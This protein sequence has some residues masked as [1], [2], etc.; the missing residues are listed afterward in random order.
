MES[1]H[2][3]ALRIIIDIHGLIDFL[4]SA[5]ETQKMAER[6]RMIEN[7]RIP[8]DDSLEQYSVVFKMVDD[9]QAIIQT[10]E[11]TKLDCETHSDTYR[12]SYKKLLNK[13]T[14][15]F[16]AFYADTQ[17]SKLKIS[18]ELANEVFTKI[19]SSSEKL[20][21]LD[22]LRNKYYKSKELINIYSKVMQTA[23][24]EL[25]I[26]DKP[27]VY[28]LI[29]WIEDD[30]KHAL[31]GY[32]QTDSK[33][34]KANNPPQSRF[35][36]LPMTNSMSLKE[37]LPLVLTEEKITV[38]STNLQQISKKI[39]AG[40]IVFNS[41][42]YTPVEYNIRPLINEVDAKKYIQPQEYGVN[43]QTIERFRTLDTFGNVHKWNFSIEIHGKDAEK[44]Y[45]LETLDGKVY[46]ALAPWLASTR[47][48]VA[49]FRV[50]KILDYDTKHASKALN[51]HAICISQATKNMFLGKALE[52][53]NFENQLTDVESGKM[54][55][56][57][58][59]AIIAVADRIV[60]KDYKNKISTPLDVSDI[61]HHPDIGRAFIN[62]V[63]G[64]FAGDKTRFDAGK[65][66]MSEILASFS[67]A[68]QTTG[69]RFVREVHN[70]YSREPLKADDIG[71]AQEK[72]RKVLSSAVELVVKLDDN[73]FT[74]NYYKYLIL[75]YAG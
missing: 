6:L 35:G 24:D 28:K 75:N 34:N 27:I 65:F 11:D 67:S 17:F 42:V 45:I 22:D 49:K 51:Y 70:G 37:L 25:F 63:V 62:S 71:Q 33:A 39:K 1:I 72:I 8:T 9:I 36:L 21:I 2:H 4:S 59:D 15:K 68:L 26:S 40:F 44:F 12:M 16:R 30:K 55:S 48:S 43:I 46:R 31:N 32:Y 57:I 3:S 66:P 60:A 38:D 74:S 73:L 13:I 52:L 64:E 29:T 50:Q 61:L 5:T 56:N 69:R 47:Y 23:I 20:K 18:E 14:A 41:I 19:L 54:Q 10:F 7:V 58:T 53:E